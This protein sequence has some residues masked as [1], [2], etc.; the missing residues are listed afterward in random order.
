MTGDEPEPWQQ[1]RTEEERAEY[2]LKYVQ[3][4]FEEL[5]YLSPE[6]IKF[7]EGIAQGAEEELD[8]CI[9][10]GVC[11]HVLKVYI[12]NGVTGHFHPNWD[13]IND[14]P[15]AMKIGNPGKMYAKVDG[16]DC[17]A[18]WVKGKATKTGETY[19]TRAVQRG[20]GLKRQV[21]YVA[22]S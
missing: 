15:L 22:H 18:F 7:F 19:A 6:L 5:S 20:H 4:S 21:A 12:L 3:R 11:P 10:A 9:Y 1:G 2:C 14:R 8:K 17:N 13:F 16:H